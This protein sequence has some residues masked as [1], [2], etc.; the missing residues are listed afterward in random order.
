M[1]ASLLEEMFYGASA[2]NGNIGAWDTSG[3]RSMEEMFYEASAFDQDIGAWDTSGV[4][5]ME[6]MFSGASAFN[7]PLSDW[8]I[9]K[10]RFMGSMFED[11][12]AFDQ[13]LGWCVRDDLDIESA[14]GGT[15][16]KDHQ[17]DETEEREEQIEEACAGDESP[18]SPLGQVLSMAA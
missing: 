16:C 6:S 7:Q 15:K 4:T 2:F 17:E 10:V 14:F 5:T 11:A 12:S 9:D 18:T 13:A 8:R 3:V 1:A